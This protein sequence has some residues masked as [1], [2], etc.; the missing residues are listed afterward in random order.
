MAKQKVFVEKEKFDAVLGMLLTAKPLPMRSVKTGGKRG[1][2]A[3][4]IPSAK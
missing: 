1:P 3:P 2:K 4:V